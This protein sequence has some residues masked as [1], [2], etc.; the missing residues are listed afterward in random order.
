MLS[1]LLAGRLPWE[2]GAVI[3][4]SCVLSSMILLIPR[5]LRPLEGQ[6]DTA[7]ESTER[8][9]QMAWFPALGWMT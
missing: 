7:E 8:G 3:G 4:D 2:R 5:F 9:G 1:E 6:P